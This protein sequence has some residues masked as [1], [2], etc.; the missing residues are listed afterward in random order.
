MVVTNWKP[1]IEIWFYNEN[2]LRFTSENYDPNNLH[3]KFGNLTNATLN[4]ENIKTNYNQ[5]DGDN[6]GSSSISLKI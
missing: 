2:Y 6:D 5:N 1:K 4:K 3:N